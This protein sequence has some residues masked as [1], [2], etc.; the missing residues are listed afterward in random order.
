MLVKVDFVQSHKQI[1]VS[2]SFLYLNISF[3]LSFPL[4]LFIYF[5]I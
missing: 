2:I 3:F 4:Y 1:N 5:F